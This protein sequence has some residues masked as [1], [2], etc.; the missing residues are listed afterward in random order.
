[1]DDDVIENA[2]HTDTTGGYLIVSWTS[3][4]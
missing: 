1:L 4:P 3:F 2:G